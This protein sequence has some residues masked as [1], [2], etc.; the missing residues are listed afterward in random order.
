[1]QRP[2]Y[3]IVIAKNGKVTVEVK[4]AS[5]KRCLE[6]ADF[7]KEVVGREDKRS[8]TAEYYAPDG[9]VRIDVKVGR[10]SGG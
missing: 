6:L 7:I 1:M 9:S 5:G 8:L 10:S 3:E 2:E 4:G